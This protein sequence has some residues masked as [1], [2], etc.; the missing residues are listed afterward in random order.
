[1][2]S[3]TMST[4]R[5]AERTGPVER[6]PRAAAL[7]LASACG[8]IGATA[9]WIGWFSV[10]PALGFP[11]VSPADMINRTLGAAPGSQLGWAI[12]LG[13]LVLLGAGYPVAAA[14]GLWWPSL[15][16]GA[17]YGVVLWFLTGA[18]LMPLMGL[19]SANQPVAAVDAMMPE[20]SA[21]SLPATMR[22]S[23]MMLHLGVLAPIG[24]LIAWLLFGGVLGATSSKFLRR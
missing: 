22:Q 24:A 2:G 11:A 17:L 16:S 1:M 12:A 14:S 7:G 15:H 10:A 3:R 21:A 4:V 13:G 9:I 20:M 23:L 19:L 5:S 18:V 6:A 8:G